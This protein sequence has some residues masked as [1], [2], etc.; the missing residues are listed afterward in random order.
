MT[1]WRRISTLLLLAALLAR[2]GAMTT[3]PPSV[4][5]Q[6]DDETAIQRVLAEEGS[7]VVAL[8][9]DRLM[10]LWTDDGVVIDARH[11]PDQPGDDLVWEGIDAVRQ[12]Y[13]YTVFNAHPS[14]A[15]PSDLQITLSG[16]ASQ[17]QVVSTTRIG[18]EVSPL[19]DRWILRK[20][21]GVWKIASLT[22]N[23][24]AASP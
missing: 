4:P 24:E 6:Q 1:L 16:D 18:A 9:I 8:D 17:A 23:L 5:S 10:A 14:Q 19:G 13:V 15:G 12:R 21:D 2:C 7:A 22:Y 20:V 3:P 11:T